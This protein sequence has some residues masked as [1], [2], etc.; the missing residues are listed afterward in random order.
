MRIFIF[1]YSDP[2]AVPHARFRLDTIILFQKKSRL[3]SSSVYI[4]KCNGLIIGLY[5][6]FLVI[7]VPFSLRNDASLTRGHNAC[8]E[9]RGDWSTFL[10]NSVTQEHRNNILIVVKKTVTV[11]VTE[12]PDLTKLIL[13]EAGFDKNVPCLF[14]GQVTSFRSQRDEAI[15]QAIRRIL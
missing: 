9:F 4:Y 1:H 11:N 13:L 2:C 14:S 7:L 8:R 15:G 10:N 12:V 3:I 6:L 5:M